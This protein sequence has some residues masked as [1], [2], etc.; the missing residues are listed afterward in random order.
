MAKVIYSLSD[1]NL[2]VLRDNPSMTPSVRKLA[3]KILNER[4]AAAA[5]K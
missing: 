1:A 4:S 3:D 2:K 5:V